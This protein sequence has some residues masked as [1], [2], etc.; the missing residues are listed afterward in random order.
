MR[1]KYIK[2]IN[3]NNIINNIIKMMNNK[4][5][6]R[7]PEWYTLRKKMITASNVASI[8][9]YNPY[10]SK[11]SILKKKV[12]NVSISN[13]AMAHGVKYEPLAIKEY[14]KKN[15]CTVD[16]VG[17]L[18][19]PTYT[20]LGASP[21]GFIISTDKLLEI[22]CVYTRDIHI[23]PYY[24]WIQVQ[25]QLEVCNKEVCDFFQCKFEDSKLVDSTLDIIKRD[26]DWFVKVLP[27]LKT[28]Q[29]DL[30]Y[31]LKKNEVNFKRKRFYSYVEWEN[32]ICSHDIKN[33]IKNDPILNYLSK[34]GDSKKKDE[35]SVYN[36]YISDSLKTIRTRIFKSISYSTTICVNKYL[37]NYE[38]IKRTKDA[39]DQKVIVIIRPLLVHANHYSIPDMLVRNDFLEKLFNIVPDKLDTNYSIV[40]ITFKK[41]T[42]KNNIIQKMDKAVIAVSY[43]DKCICDKVQKANTSVYLLNKQNK[44]GKLITDDNSKLLEKIARGVEWLTELIRDGEDFDVLNPDRW[45]LYPNM[46]NHSDYGWHS[47][48]KELADNAN[49]LTT[50]WNIGINKRKELHHKG[51][52]RWDDVEKEDVPAKVF[53]II[54][55][56]KSRKKYMNVVNS[57]PQG[58]K[59][60]FVDFETVNNLST[61]NFK[62]NSLIYII[63]CGYIHN[64][65]W[66]F[67]QFKLNTYDLKEEKDMILK[68]INFMY[69][70]K[71]EFLVCHWCSAEKT[72]FRQARERHSMKYNPLENNFFDLCKYF[73]DNKIVV[74]GS[75]TYKLKNI[76]KALFNHQLIE[77]NWADNEIDGLSATLYG[78]YDLTNQDKSNVADTLHYNMIDCKVMYDII[79]FIKKVK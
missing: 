16:E 52:Y 56:N 59:Y 24:Y 3:Y 22:K 67:K 54:K 77:T 66:K 63:G 11:V 43:L 10:D 61:D 23:V 76:A 9:G 32:Y 34:Y 51:I 64:N 5:K 18:V 35:A 19:H 65:K 12:N 21:D 30:L 45:E 47:Y 36:K 20:W 4:I 53:Q 69:G 6:Q 2:V 29:K 79:K 13:A 62:A 60:F 46:C 49:E 42:I 72:F 58:K 31:C 73:I 38:S 68:W 37:K 27:E 8:L 50:I 15:K 57:L 17:L 78:W 7:T 33:Y 55:V 71:K 26:R 44:I 25:I 28:F 39:I 48:K 75:F 40:Q 74:N 14:E 70:F 1:N 41:L